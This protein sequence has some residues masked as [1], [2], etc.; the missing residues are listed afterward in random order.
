MLAILINFLST[1]GLSGYRPEV[2]FITIVG[3]SS[4]KLVVDD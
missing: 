1:G 2:S 4:Y 3:N